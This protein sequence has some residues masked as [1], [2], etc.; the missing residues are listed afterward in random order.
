MLWVHSVHAPPQ[1]QGRCGLHDASHRSI[2]RAPGQTNH[3]EGT[4]FKFPRTSP[5]EQEKRDGRHQ[6]RQDEVQEVGRRPIDDQ[7][8]GSPRPAL[9]G[10]GEV[11]ARQGGACGGEGGRSPMLIF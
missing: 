9:R 7:E 11:Q 3:G 2:Q 5:D 6:D 8:G 4:D 1:Q 10:E